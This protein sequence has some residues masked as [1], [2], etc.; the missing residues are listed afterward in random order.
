MTLA[1]YR[2]LLEQEQVQSAASISQAEQGNHLSQNST[3]GGQWQAHQLS[4]A[5]WPPSA[6][7]PVLL[8]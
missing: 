8:R 2:L 6:A 3:S 1:D 5:A 4:M 7:L